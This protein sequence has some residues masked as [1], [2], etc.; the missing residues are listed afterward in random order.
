MGKFFDWIVE[1]VYDLY[2]A[3]NDILHGPNSYSKNRFKD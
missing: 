2:Y 1:F 3:I